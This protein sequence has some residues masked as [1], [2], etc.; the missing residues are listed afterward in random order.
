MSTPQV[1]HAA[2]HHITYRNMTDK[3]MVFLAA[4]YRSTREAELARVPWSDLEKNAFSE[5]Q[6]KAQHTHYQEHYP[7]AL[8]LII[9]Q[10]GTAIG[11]LYL[12]RWKT[13][14]RIIDIIIH[15]DLRGQG[16]G[17]SILRDLQEEAAIS[18]KSVSIH[19]EK[20]NPAM[21]LYHRIQFKKIEDK[22]V[23]DLLEWTAST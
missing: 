20:E 1:L 22:G 6:F 2:K 4:L 23:Y 3:D 16:I 19:V 15:P 18:R 8:W 11:R 9:E 10:N 5:M 14:H 21:D 12:E 7:D 13:T 17:K